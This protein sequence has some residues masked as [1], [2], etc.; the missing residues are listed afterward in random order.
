MFV[1]ESFIEPTETDEGDNAPRQYIQ[2][3]LPQLE[4]ITSSNQHR[5][6]DSQT[7]YTKARLARQ[8]PEAKRTTEQIGVLEDMTT[9]RRFAPYNGAYE[10][11]YTPGEL[12]SLT[13]ELTTLSQRNRPDFA[14]IEGKVL[15]VVLGAVQTGSAEVPQNVRAIA[16]RAE[17]DADNR[18]GMQWKTLT[19]LAA[20]ASLVIRGNATETLG[21]Y[22]VDV[23][24][25]EATKAL[26]L[27]AVYQFV[28]DAHALDI[29]GARS[30]AVEQ[31]R[32]DAF[33]RNCEIVNR[34]YGDVLPKLSELPTDLKAGGSRFG[35]VFEI[36]QM[37]EC[38]NIRLAGEERSGI[39]KDYR[40][41]PAGA[42]SLQKRIG[43]ITN[44]INVLLSGSEVDESEI[45]PLDDEDDGTN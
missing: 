7:V 37:V 21:E 44:A 31:D 17:K 20:Q 16:Q 14:G 39:N 5:Y 43:H 38:M 3:L 11:V 35:A 18:K 23:K 8:V 27:T 40:R 29:M 2:P 41:D 32:K 10:D 26:D 22:L 6:D 45:V 15:D 19:T 13:F 34:W 4:H 30:V 12:H 28:A 24:D 9:L 33:V 36:K 25:P 1:A 42:I